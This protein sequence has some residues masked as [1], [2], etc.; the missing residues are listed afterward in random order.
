MEKDTYAITYQVSIQ[1]VSPASG[2]ER[3]ADRCPAADL[4]FHSISFPSE[5]GLNNKQKCFQWAKKFP[6]N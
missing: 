4:C 6:F 3:G 5:W 1:L 2:D